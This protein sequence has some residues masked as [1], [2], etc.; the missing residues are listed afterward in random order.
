[1]PFR[2]AH[3]VVGEL[4]RAH[5]TSGTAL[6]ELVAADDRLGPEAAGVLAPGV[7]VRRRTSPGGGG[8]TPVAEQFVRYRESLRRQRES[9]AG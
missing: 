7:G 1:M 2:D 8:P 9:L 6:S 5:L 3:A 4:V